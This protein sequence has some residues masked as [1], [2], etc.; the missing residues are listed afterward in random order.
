MTTWTYNIIERTIPPT[1][2]RMNFIAAIARAMRYVERVTEERVRFTHRGFLK[3]GEV[4]D[5]KH[6]VNI[7]FDELGDTTKRIGEHNMI[8]GV[9]SIAFDPN[10]KWGWNWFQRVILGRQDLYT[11]A[12]HE[13]G[14]LLGLGH[15]IRL[16]ERSVM[17]PFPSVAEFSPGEIAQLKRT[18]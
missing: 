15:N 12:V 6:H 13:L 8:N 1:M 18:A 16:G 5:A 2:D 10:V 4:V 17:E 7:G 9:N 14:H 11:I 3:P